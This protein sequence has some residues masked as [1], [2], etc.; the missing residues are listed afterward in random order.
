MLKEPW[1]GHTI[2]H[3]EQ[4]MRTHALR[5]IL[6]L[7]SSATCLEA[8]LSGPSGRADQCR[9]FM[10]LRVCVCVCINPLR[11]TL[12]ECMDSKGEQR[13]FGNQLSSDLLRSMTSSADLQLRHV[14]LLFPDFICQF[15]LGPYSFVYLILTSVTSSISS[16]SRAAEANQFDKNMTSTKAQICVCCAFPLSGLIIGKHLFCFVYLKWQGANIAAW[17]FFLKCQY[18]YTTFM[19]PGFDCWVLIFS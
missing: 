5:L 9:G 19:P 8:L 3:I 7:W 6:M 2:T 4:H 11:I 10:C 17:I 14:L 13:P 15:S 16:V 12:C 18:N 1:L